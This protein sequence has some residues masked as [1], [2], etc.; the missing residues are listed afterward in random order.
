LKDPHFEDHQIH[1]TSLFVSKCNSKVLLCW[2][3][4]ISS[5]AIKFWG[6]C[7]SSCLMGTDVP[8]KLVLQKN[9]LSGLCC[10]LLS[11]LV[12]ARILLPS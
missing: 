1:R 4:H 6:K 11:Q 10:F 12:V 9:V 2:R 3:Y 8:I 5:F 7:N